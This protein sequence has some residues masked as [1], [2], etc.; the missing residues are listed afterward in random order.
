MRL[1]RGLRIQEFDAAGNLSEYET[2]SRDSIHL[3]VLGI[4]SYLLQMQPVNGLA[5]A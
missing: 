5:Q 1:E 4:I 2:L 3:R